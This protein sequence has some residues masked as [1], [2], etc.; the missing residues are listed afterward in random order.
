MTKYNGQ[1][2]RIIIMKMRK[3]L[4]ALC[5][6]VLSL[7]IAGC[8]GGEGSSSGVE[9]TDGKNVDNK[10]DKKE[11][12]EIKVEDIDWSIEEGIVDNKRCVLFSYTNKSD[13]TIAD[14]ELK[15]KAKDDISDEEKNKFYSDIQKDFEFSDEDMNELKEEEISMSTGTERLVEPGETVDSVRCHYYSGSYY[16]N[17]ISHYNLMQ[18]DIMT[19]KYIDGEDIY[20]EYYDFVSEK[21]SND[22]KSESAIQW[23]GYDIGNEI[24]KPNS[25]RIEVSMDYDDSFDFDAYG[26]SIDEFDEYVSSCKEKGFTENAVDQDGWYDADRKDGYSVLLDYDEEN[27]KIDVHISYHETD[28]TKE[29]SEN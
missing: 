21:Y 17:D 9:S 15:F 11:P 7:S 6:G 22:K 29:D 14:V 18:P 27:Y 2:E 4:I 16:F 19:I 1:K 20:T 26:I 8:S 5:L 3:L 12:K 24:D 10:N 13:C 23:S 25:K 28:V